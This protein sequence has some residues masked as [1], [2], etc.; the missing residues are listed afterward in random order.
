MTDVL[1]CFFA[2]SKAIELCKA[3]MAESAEVLVEIAILRCMDLKFLLV[4]FAKNGRS[5]VALEVESEDDEVVKSER[6]SSCVK[7]SF[8]SGLNWRLCAR[9]PY[10][11]VWWLRGLA[12]FVPIVAIGAKS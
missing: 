4:V 11:S 10:I 8:S 9:V 12:K 1:A 6:Y 3:A 5:A 2:F 7:S